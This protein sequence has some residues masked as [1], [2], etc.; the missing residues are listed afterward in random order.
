MQR[1][2]GGVRSLAYYK[3]GNDERQ[4]PA[5]TEAFRRLVA[6]ET[7]VRGPQKTRKHVPAR[8]VAAARVHLPSGSDPMSPGIIRIAE[9]G[10]S[11]N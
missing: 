8:L 1:Q 9:P 3:D 5:F 11:I 10:L 7:S 2:S 6:I 4:D